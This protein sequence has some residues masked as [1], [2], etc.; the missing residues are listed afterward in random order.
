MTFL[1]RTIVLQEEERRL[2]AQKYL[3]AAIAENEALKVSQKVLKDA[4]R[5][6]DM[7]MQG[8]L[9]LCTGLPAC[10]KP[11]TDHWVFMAGAVY[12]EQRA[13]VQEAKKK[14]AAEA[15]AERVKLKERM[16]EVR[17]QRFPLGSL[18]V[19]CCCVKS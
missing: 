11:S 9:T 5:A 17:L 6:A 13:E 16:V 2:Q 7:A 3:T 1:E 10:C 4:E 8:M 15:A 12:A 19:K 14:A 18:A